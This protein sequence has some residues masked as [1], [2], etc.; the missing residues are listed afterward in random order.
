MEIESSGAKKPAEISTVGKSADSPAL[1][2]E[3]EVL[4]KLWESY[5][6]MS[7]FFSNLIGASLVSLV[8]F[9]YIKDNPAILRSD[10][11]VAGIGFV[12]VA[13]FLSIVWRWGSQWSM[14]I[15]IMGGPEGIDQFFARANRRRVITGAADTGLQRDMEQT[16]TPYLRRFMKA[17][18][19]IIL[20]T[21]LIGGVLIIVAVRNS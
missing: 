6:A 2:K 17:A 21:Y 5:I 11:M 15:E 20:V 14:E 3:I 16:M 1:A 18:A 8:A 7:T 13:F 19:G 9:P 4:Q 12:G 10:F